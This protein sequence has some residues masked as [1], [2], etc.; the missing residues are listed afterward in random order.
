METVLWLCPSLPTE[1]LKW[2][3]SLPIL[4]QVSFWWWQ[5]S[6]RYI[7]SLSP[8]LHTPF[9]PSLI[10]L[11]VSVDVKHHVYLFTVFD[12]M[13]LRGTVC[14]FF[15]FFITLL[16]GQLHTVFRWAVLISGGWMLLCKECIAEVNP[17]IS[18]YAV[19]SNILCSLGVLAGVCVLWCSPNHGGQTISKLVVHYLCA[20]M[21]PKPGWSNY[22]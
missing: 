19:H 20:V 13:R 2:L 14:P 7:I 22:Q 12:G 6:N 9:Y 8:H 1:T 15:N 10:S 4:M 11:M 3:S 21:Q 5:C 16:H 17:Y 18:I